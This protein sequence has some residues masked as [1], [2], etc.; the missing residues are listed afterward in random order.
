MNKIIKIKNANKYVNKLENS[1]KIAKICLH[2]HELTY[3]GERIG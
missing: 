3:K 1:I 2:S